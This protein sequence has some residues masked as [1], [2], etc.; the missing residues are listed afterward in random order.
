MKKL[1]LLFIMAFLSLI[2]LEANASSIWFINPVNGQTV[3]GDG[4]GSSQTT[5]PLNLQYNQQ[6]ISPY[7]VKLFAAPKGTYQSNQGE[8][9]PQWF[10]LEPGTYSWRLELWEGNGLGQYFKTAEQTITFY[11]KHTITVSN[12]FYGGNINIDNVI[13]ASGSN[14]IKFTG[15]NLLIGAIDQT[16]NGQYYL[17]NQNGTNNSVWK[18]KPM[19][20]TF[21][22]IYGG[23]PRN[24]NYTVVSNDNGAEIQAAMRARYDITR[25]DQ[26]LEF[27]NTFNSANVQVIEGNDLLAPSPQTVGGVSY[28]FVNWSD[29]LTDNPRTI[30]SGGTFTAKYKAIHKSDDASAFSNNGQRKL[31]ETKSGSTTWLH[32]VYTSLGHIWIEHSSNYG[33]SWI[34]GNNGQPLDGSAGGKNPSIAYTNDS[35]NNYNYIGVVWQQPYNS[36]YKIVGMTFSQNTSSSTI[37]GFASEVRTLHTES[38]DAYSVNAN[39]NFVLAG[40]AFG[41]YLVTFERKSTSGSWQPGINWLVGHIEDV[42]QS[43]DGPFGYVE[44]NGLVSG[45]NSSSINIQMS[46]YPDYNTSIDIAVNLLRQQGSPGTIYSH[47]LFLTKANGYWQYTQ[48]DDGMISYNSPVN[49]APSI[50]SL[51]DYVYS[52]CWIEYTDM[53]FYFYDSGVRYYFGSNGSGAVS[54][55][56]NRGGGNSNGG[57]AGWSIGGTNRSIRFDNGIPVTSSIRNLSTTG[58]YVQ[59]GNGTGSDLSNMYVSS[60]YPTS[61]PY[62]F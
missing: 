53:T 14:A 47:F 24:F 43:Y 39:P 29:G 8:G 38:S 42:A 23:T 31:I 54:C 56:I 4:F 18:K 41:P 12:N 36:T 15:D 13:K 37:P 21:A 58:R 20:G 17:W 44:A 34:L 28:N 22:N 1:F 16:Y 51:N 59:V 49:S 5:V 11:V 45:T 55:S 61:S 52:A 32:Q 48:Y 33:S 19:N 25:N 30:Y 3:T 60:F 2:T 50:V 62:Y 6:A 46:P 27:G 9:I 35:W 57:F 7:Y 40:A 26:S 10:Y